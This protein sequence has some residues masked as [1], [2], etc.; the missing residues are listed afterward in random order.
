MRI[1]FLLL[2]SITLL[3]ISCG[4]DTGEGKPVNIYG[5]AG[6]T[7]SYE[8]YGSF[9]YKYPVLDE[10]EFKDSSGAAT[11]PLVLPNSDIIVSTV[12]GNI[13]Y[14]SSKQVK[15]S[16]KL[17]TDETPSASIAADAN[18]NIYIISTTGKLYSIT[19]AGLLNWKK[20]IIDS[21]AKYD[22]ISDLLAQENGIVTAV[23]NGKIIKVGYNGK[24]KWT[25]TARLSPIKTFSADE[26][27]NIY[28]PLTHD[29]FG[30]TDTLLCLS[31]DGKVVW[32]KGFDNT[33][34]IKSPVV[35]KSR[36]IIFGIRESGE[37]KISTV[38]YLEVNGKVLWKKEILLFARNLSVDLDGRIYVTG[39]NSGIGE[40]MSG[41]FCYS[42]EG[43]LIWKNYFEVIIPSSPLLS[44]KY[45][46]FV[47]NDKNS[48]GL[49][50]L[51]KDGTLYEVVGLE[52]MPPLYLQ[53]AVTSDP[54]IIF[55]G[56]DRLSIVS[57]EEAPFDKFLP[58]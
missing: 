31:S 44:K 48:A 42:P 20:I 23:S 55:S 22:L 17:D 29:E 40:A 39:Y 30:K 33:R 43:K 24:V 21:L 35:F 34:F 49:Y 12:N 1:F 28:I 50:F 52:N 36:V 19:K 13:I 26:K 8:K 6:R 53:P 54:L 47:V 32:Q 18:M 9:S 5:G 7:N 14:I 56:A 3:L 58:W 57:I 11:A 25:Y 41:I 51:K 45:I 10:I 46:G 2:L 16:F 37:Q 15:W 4:S 27:G 38:N